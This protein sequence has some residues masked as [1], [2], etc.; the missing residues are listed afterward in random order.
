MWETYA[1]K[2]IG[3]ANSVSTSNIQDVSYFGK[4]VEDKWRRRQNIYGAVI[5]ATA[6]VCQVTVKLDVTNA[7]GTPKIHAL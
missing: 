7:Q 1:V 4:R 6:V 2:N 5:S 3:F